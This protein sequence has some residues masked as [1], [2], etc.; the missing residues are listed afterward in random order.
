[1]RNPTYEERL[2]FVDTPCLYP[3][4]CDRSMVMAVNL[5]DVVAAANGVPSQGVLLC[6]AHRGRFCV[7]CGMLEGPTQKN[8]GLVSAWGRDIGVE[9]VQGRRPTVAATCRL[10]RTQKLCE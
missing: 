1:M 2:S 9:Q 5:H 7:C 10:S 6:A 8:R 4:C 3:G